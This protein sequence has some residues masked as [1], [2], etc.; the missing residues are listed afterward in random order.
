MKLDKKEV[1]FIRVNEQIIESILL[2]RISDL[3]DEILDVPDEK[4]ESWIKWL[5]EYKIA[6][7]LLKEITKENSAEDFTGI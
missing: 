5:K 7:G 6:L 4:R 2:K 1:Q 3:K